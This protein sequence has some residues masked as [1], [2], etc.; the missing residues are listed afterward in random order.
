MA[1]SWDAVNVQ[2]PFYRQN[3]G[4]HILC[5]GIFPDSGIT[6][7]FTSRKKRAALMESYCMSCY[8]QCGLYR[9]IERKYEG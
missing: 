5:E 4:L 1:T 8:T 6:T 7:T 2:C 3:D 9:Q